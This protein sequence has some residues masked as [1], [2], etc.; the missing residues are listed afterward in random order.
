MC[1]SQR[2]FSKKLYSGDMDTS[3]TQ[4]VSS[5]FNNLKVTAL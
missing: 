4:I 2:A 3:F 5:Y 1:G